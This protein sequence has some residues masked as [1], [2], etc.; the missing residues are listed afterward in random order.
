MVGT[1]SLEFPPAFSEGL[2][3]KLVHLTPEQTKVAEAAYG[4]AETFHAHVLSDVIFGAPARVLAGDV[5]RFGGPVYLY[6]FSVVSA[7][8]PK[9][10]QGG[11]VHA[12][13]R[14]YVFKT[15]NASPWPTDARD[16]RLAETISAYWVAFAKTGDP[17]GGG[18][19]VWPRYGKDDRLINFTNDGP[20]AEKTPDAAALDLIAAGLPKQ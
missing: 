3:E 19:Q 2:T 7:A 14:Q 12:S 8:A 10:V 17:N 20:K 9:A 1:N 5:A 18:R 4:G 13:D 11:A 16:A 6:R 15:L